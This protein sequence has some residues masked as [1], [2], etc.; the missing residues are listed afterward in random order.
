MS[1]GRF[2]QLGYKASY[3]ICSVFAAYILKEKLIEATMLKIKNSRDS[4]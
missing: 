2:G 4:F 1:S 3:E